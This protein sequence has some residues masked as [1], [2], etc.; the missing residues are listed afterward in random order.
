MDKHT[1]WH[2]INYT[3]LLVAFVVVYGVL[4]EYLPRL[5]RGQ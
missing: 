4:M 3:A 5:L 1:K 2:I